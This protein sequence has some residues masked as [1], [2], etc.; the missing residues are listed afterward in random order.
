MAQEPLFGGNVVGFPG[1][2]LLQELFQCLTIG[3]VMIHETIFTERGLTTAE[4]SFP[5]D[6]RGLTLY[7]GRRAADDSRRGLLP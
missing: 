7:K 1:P 2:L 6:Y 3:R 4:S 5:T